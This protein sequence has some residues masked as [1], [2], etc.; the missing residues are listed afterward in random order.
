MSNFPD[1]SPFTFGSMSLGQEPLNLKPDIAVARQA[2]ESGVWFHSSPTYNKGFTYMVL[3]MAFDEAPAQRPKLVIKIRDAEPR[4]V[5]F[6]VE[7]ALRRLG[8]DQIDVI[9]LVHDTHGPS[10][11]VEGFQQ[12][13]ERRELVEGFKQAGKV[14]KAVL[15]FEQDR[16]PQCSEA[17]KAGLFDGVTFYDNLMQYDVP[18]SV[19]T[20]LDE[21]PEFPVLALRTVYGGAATAA[22]TDVKKEQD[23]ARLK[24]LGELA[25]KADCQDLVE[26]SIR[27]ILCHGNV[28]TTIGGTSNAQH[29]QRYLE[30]AAN[31]Q[32]LPEAVVSEIEKIRRA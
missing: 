26:L 28:R 29:L 4:L 23:A 8:V 15:F 32:P 13:D 24:R 14:G 16:A 22:C 18:E 7:D 10:T 3:R 12:G 17:L 25:Q 2:M 9:Q 19:A 6:E 21:H 20:F 31:L 27:F 30:V 5:R 1:M 11:V